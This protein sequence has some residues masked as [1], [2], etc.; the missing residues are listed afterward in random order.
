MPISDARKI[1]VLLDNDVKITSST[2]DQ[3]AF[4]SKAINKQVGFDQDKKPFFKTDLSKTKTPLDQ[5]F[6]NSIGGF[7][8]DKLKADSLNAIQADHAKTVI[9]NSNNEIK[10]DIKIE[11][12]FNQPTDAPKELLKASESAIKDLKNRS[13][14]EQSPTF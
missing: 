2:F 4:D 14:L 11:Q 3:N 10:Q 9:K 13:Q 8:L 7:S 5:L 6:K 1:E 12:T